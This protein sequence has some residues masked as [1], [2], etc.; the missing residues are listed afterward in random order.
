MQ[1]NKL[2]EFSSIEKLN[3]ISTFFGCHFHLVISEVVMGSL[4]NGYCGLIREVNDSMDGIVGNAISMWRAQYEGK[5]FKSEADVI[6]SFMSC[7]SESRSIQHSVVDM[8]CFKDD[9]Q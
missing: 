7:L 3:I 8:L 4:G 9:M 2:I 6:A 5:A 1:E